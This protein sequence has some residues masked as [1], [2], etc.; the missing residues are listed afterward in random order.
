MQLLLHKQNKYRIIFINVP[1]V[2]QALYVYQNQ[3]TNHVDIIKILA[4]N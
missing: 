4:N 2:A 1:L 3:N